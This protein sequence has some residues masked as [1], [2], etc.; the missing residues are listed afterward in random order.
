TIKALAGRRAPVNAVAV[1]ALAEKM[2]SGTAS[3]PGDV[4]RTAS[5]KTYEIMSTDAEGRMVLVDALW[6]VQ[7]YHDPAVVIDIATLTGAI[8]R[9][10]GAD[11]EGLFSRDDALAGQL[12]PA[13]ESSGELLRWM[14]LYH[15]YGRALRS[16]IADMLNGGGR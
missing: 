5:G 11:Y 2:P 8:V 14:P 7:E 13:G 15:T 4:V 16:P 10:L 9:A 12:L 6:Y 1:A 3:R